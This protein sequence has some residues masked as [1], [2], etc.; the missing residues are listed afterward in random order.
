MR[1]PCPGNWCTDG[2]EVCPELMRKVNGMLALQDNPPI[3]GPESQPLRQRI[4][5]WWVAHTKAR[6]EK[7]LA[8]NLLNQNITYFLPMVERVTFSG[9]RKRRGMTPLFPSYVF[10]CGSLDDRLAALTT[11]RLCQVIEVGDQELLLNELCDI[12]RVLKSPGNLA[13]FSFAAVGQLCRVKCG[14]L[15]GLQ[16]IVMQSGQRTQLVL[17]VTMLGQSVA[18]EIEAGLL[19]P[20]V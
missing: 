8:W 5:R 2:D 14:P 17:Q 3:L 20:A 15:Q 16:G 9:G 12:E 1:W 13:P 7:A 19:E 4:G 11:D 6:C 10:F 18:L